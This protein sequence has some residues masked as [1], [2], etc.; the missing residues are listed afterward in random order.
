MSGYVEIEN[1]TEEASLFGV[2][3]FLAG[4]FNRKGYIYK[5]TL[6]FEH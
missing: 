5:T 2:I 4:L 3:R 1:H 6:Y